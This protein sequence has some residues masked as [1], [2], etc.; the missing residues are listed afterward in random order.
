MKRLGSLRRYRRFRAASG[1]TLVELLT[2][3]AIVGVLAA[4]AVILVGQHFRASKSLE[5]TSIIQAIRAAQEARRAETGSY[6]NVTV[7]DTWYPAAPTG[8]VKSAWRVS[9]PAPGSNAARWQQLGVAQTDATQFGFKTW[10]G[11]PG[12]VAGFDLGLAAAPTFPEATDLWYVI[13]AA[14][15]IDSDTRLS[16]FVA[17]SF[18]AELYIENEG[19]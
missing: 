10:A 1:F 9:A 4:V 2:V 11:N 17:T 19:E 13:E 18:N 7:E 3:V 15:D 6:Q 8:K 5:A 16:R 12:P 14:G